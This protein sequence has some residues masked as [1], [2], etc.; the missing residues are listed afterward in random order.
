MEDCD[1]VRT[2]LVSVHLTMLYDDD[3]QKCVH[4]NAKVKTIQFDLI[5]PHVV[6]IVYV[7]KIFNFILKSITF[8]TCK[9]YTLLRL[10][11]SKRSK[12][13]DCMPYYNVAEY[14]KTIT[15][16]HNRTL[17]TILRLYF[18]KMNQNY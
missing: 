16:A 9:L 4:R 6:C 5:T 2:N 1:S 12:I 3:Q 7:H 15:A 8:A 10:D 13:I 18:F 11:F 17:F 14:N